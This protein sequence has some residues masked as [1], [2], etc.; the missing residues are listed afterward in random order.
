MIIGIGGVSRA[1]KSTLADL[2]MKQLLSRGYTVA[3]FRQDDYPIDESDLPMIQD[4]RDWEI[5]G[6]IQ[7][8]YFYNLINSE[9]EKYNITII[10]GLFCFYDQR[11]INMMDKKILVEVDKPTFVNRKLSDLRWGSAPEPEWYIDH[12]WDSYQIHGVPH[13]LNDYF[14]IDGSHYFNLVEVIKYLE[15]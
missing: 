2:L 9:L 7:H 6:S 8:E 10:E 12:I 4:R 1:G 15:S 14:I 5:P 11:L 13:K 3:V